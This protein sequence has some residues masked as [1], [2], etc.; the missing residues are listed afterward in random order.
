MSFFMKFQKFAIPKYKI[1]FDSCYL[2]MTDSPAIP[3]KLPGLLTS[4]LCCFFVVVFK[5]SAK[6]FVTFD[7]AV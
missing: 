1:S 5:K 2:T 7:F 3:V 6:T 4:H